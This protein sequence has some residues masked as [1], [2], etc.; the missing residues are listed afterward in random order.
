MQGQKSWNGVAILCKGKEPLL[1]HG[2]LLGDPDDTH[3]RYVEVAIDGIVI[4][5]LYLPNGNPAP[6]PKFDYELGWLERLS[7]QAD[8]LLALNVPVI[9]AGEC[10]VIPVELDVYRPERWIDDELFQI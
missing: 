3:S 9:L 6:G 7:T 2:G 1:T 8:E 4:G 10:N 5:C